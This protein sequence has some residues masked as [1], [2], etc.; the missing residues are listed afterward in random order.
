MGFVFFKGMWIAQAQDIFTFFFFDIKYIRT[1]LFY[2][3]LLLVLKKGIANN[4]LNGTIKIVWDINRHHD[5]Q[6]NSSYSQPHCVYNHAF[7]N[8][9]NSMFFLNKGENSCQKH[10]GGDDKVLQLWHSLFIAYV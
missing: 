9:Y 5:E 3:N 6:E 10:N 1:T 8:C 7:A 4:W 2:F